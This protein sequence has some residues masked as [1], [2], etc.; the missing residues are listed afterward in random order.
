[1]A[2][3]LSTH[4]PEYVDVDKWVRLLNQALPGVP[5]SIW[6]QL[7]DPDRIEL[8][9]GDFAAPG[10]Y[11]S[12]KN[13]KC[14]M[15]I[16]A[17][18]DA[19]LRDPEFP[20]HIPLV[21]SD[22]YAIAFQV[23]QYVVLQILD[24]HRHGAAYRRQQ[25]EGVWRPIPTAD[26]RSLTV[27]LLGYGR[28]GK[29][30]AC[31]LRSLE[32]QICA[33]SRTAKPEAD[34]IAHFH[35]DESLPALLGRSDYV[36][37]ALPLTPHTRGIINRATIAAMKRGAFIINV[38]RGA[39][40][41]DSDLLDALREGQICGAAL[42]VFHKEPLPTD[43]PFWTHPQVTVT[44]HVANFWVDGSL[45]QVVDLWRRLQEGRTIGPVVDPDLGY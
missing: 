18:V 28:I 17:G 36:V 4:Y 33:W 44:P 15:Y 8:M 41:L 30:T 27:G 29:A 14:F 31:T 35:G 25:V 45:P 39:H 19:I 20:R 6:P 43:H 21:R 23:A 37:C 5:V 32:F 10:I 13:L 34:G 26:T 2:I 38:G 1:M 40:V 24:H 9:I 42:D 11:P 22:D 7:E 3:L 12:L 16:G